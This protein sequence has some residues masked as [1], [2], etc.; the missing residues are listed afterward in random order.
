MQVRNGSRME[1]WRQIIEDYQKSRLSNKAYCEQ[2]EFS[3]KTFY[4]WR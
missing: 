1:Q 2:H 3:E 4:H